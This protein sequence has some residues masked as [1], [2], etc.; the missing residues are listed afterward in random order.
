MQA[1]TVND[2]PLPVIP[3]EDIVLSFVAVGDNLIHGA[4]YHDARISSNAYDFIPMYEPVRADIESADIAFINQETI[5]GG[6]A[7]G[8]SHYPMFNSPEEVAAAISSLGFDLVNHATNHTL[9]KGE[10]GVLNTLA[11]WSQY[12]DIVV[13]GIHN[14]KEEQER[15]PIL[16]RNGIK[17]AFLAYTQHTNGLQPPS[18]K[19][20]LVD[21]IDKERIERDVHKAKEVA[22][23]VIVSM[24]WG[25]E[26]TFKANEYQKEY[27]AFLHDLKVDVVIGTHPHTIQ[28]VEL[29]QGSDH[30]TLVMYSLGN[31]LSAQDYVGNMLELMMKWSIRIQQDPKKVTIEDVTCVPLINHF[32]SGFKEFRVYPYKN[33]TEELLK[34]HGLQGYKGQTMTFTNITKKFNEVL[35]NGCKIDL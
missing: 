16:E 21:Y 23:L 26:D 35:S 9:D 32:Q 24:H 2:D 22:D 19:S 8:L 31:F 20:Y 25:D 10:K 29:K 6:K 13:N 18:G 1:P 14:N 28:P 4:V 12:T 34:Q 15:I 3:K 17:L 33:Y 7:M 27:A 11:T 5:L 30:Q